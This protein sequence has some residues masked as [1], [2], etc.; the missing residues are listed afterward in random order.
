MF[1]CGAF[2][3]RCIDS[4]R[5][6]GLSEN[7]YEVIVVNDGSVDD[8]PE[9]V[10]GYC[11]KYSNIVLIN[12]HNKGV[13]AARNLGLKHA[14]GEWVHFVDADDFLIDNGYKC[15][16]GGGIWQIVKYLKFHPGP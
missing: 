16:I 14:H 5:S 3:S 8:G 7:E 13:S 12:Q 6:Q 1:N 4:I 2:I 10:S 9:I 11:D 15:L